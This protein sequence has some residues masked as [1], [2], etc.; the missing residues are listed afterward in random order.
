MMLRLRAALPAVFVAAG[1]ALAVSVFVVS[2]VAPTA[3]SEEKSPGE[4]QYGDGRGGKQENPSRYDQ[5]YGNWTE[6]RIESWEAGKGIAG[7]RPAQTV[8]RTRTLSYY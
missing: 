1:L 5:F 4:A 7:L 8:L 2:V 3:R 6:E